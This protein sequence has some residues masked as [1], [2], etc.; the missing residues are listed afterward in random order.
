MAISKERLEELI[1]QGATIW[2]D[3]YGE[4]K[5][6]K[7]SCEICEVKSLN[8]IHMGWVLY[9]DY[10]YDNVTNHTEVNIEH[11]EEDVEIAK[12]HYEMDCSRIEYLNL[13]TYE[14]MLEK[15]HFSFSQKLRSYPATIRFEI[16]RDII[17]VE[18][19][20]TLHWNWCGITKENY[21]EACRLA[22]RLFLGKN[23]EV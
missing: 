11:L 20:N 6:D 10:S 13:P 19:K 9:F 3:D 22:K 14:E 1:E 12:W 4:I 8:D 21:I 7:N 18:D 15:R 16:G 5:L 2:H 17:W 23:Y